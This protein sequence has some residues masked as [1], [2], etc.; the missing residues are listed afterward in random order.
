M[1]KY[2][3]IL[4]MAL[5]L[6]MVG[7]GSDDET[8]LSFA[9]ESVEVN[10]NESLSLPVSGGE[11]VVYTSSDETIA[12]V[13]SKG[14]VKGLLVGEVIITATSGGESA[15]C[16]V[17]V[18]PTLSTYAEPYVKYACKP[19]DIKAKETRTLSSET[20]SEIIYA[21]ENT[22]VKTVTYSMDSATGMFGATVVL[23]S[24]AGFDTV[25]SFLTERYPLTNSAGGA[26]VFENDDMMITLASSLSAGIVVTYEPFPVVK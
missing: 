20:V 5:M 11:T 25:K 15:T 26:Y 23:E 22:N 4:A 3:G 2:I 1:K 17:V 10:Y 21:G 19:S 9:S 13:D 6:V 12:T 7:C 8:A 18:K 14:N 24:S 16:K